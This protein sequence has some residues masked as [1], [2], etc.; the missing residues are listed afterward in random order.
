[1]LSPLCFKRTE[2]L[3]LLP[4]PLVIG[5]GSAEPGVEY[6]FGERLGGG[7]QAEGQHIG[8][9]PDAGPAGSLGIATERRADA[10]HLIRR[11]GGAGARPTADDAFV[12]LARRHRLGH[13]PADQWP[14]RVS[15][16]FGQWAKRHDLVPTAPQLL[17]QGIGEVRP[18]VAA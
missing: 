5:I 14:I 10:R 7:T 12:G 3:D 13:S 15:I 4:I 18:L 17:H 11:D 6:L 2:A 8:M 1:M 9:I 16:T